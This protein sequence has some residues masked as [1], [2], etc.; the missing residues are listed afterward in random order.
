MISFGR[1]FGRKNCVYNI[2]QSTLFLIHPGPLT[3]QSNPSPA[4][5]GSRNPNCHLQSVRTAIE[6]LI[7]RNRSPATIASRIDPTAPVAPTNYIPPKCLEKTGTTLILPFS[8]LH[9]HHHHLQTHG[10]STKCNNRPLPL[11][12]RRCPYQIITAFW[13]SF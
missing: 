9:H 1:P 8:C 5:M 11:F 4:F 13:T 10:T 2:L 3:P 12:H 6:D 7:P